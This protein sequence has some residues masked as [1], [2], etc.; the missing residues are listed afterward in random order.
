MLGANAQ[1]RRATSLGAML[2]SWVESR[3]HVTG[4]AQALLFVTYIAIVIAVFVIAP[5]LRRPKRG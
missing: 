1:Q 5:D 3:A 2:L 4:G